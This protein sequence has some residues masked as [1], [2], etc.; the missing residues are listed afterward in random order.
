M[1][2][3]EPRP[4]PPPDPLVP[5][6]RTPRGMVV[7]ATA[8]LSGFVLFSAPTLWKEYQGLRGD[9]AIT[10]AAAPLGFVDIAPNPSFAEP[11]PD[12]VHAEGGDL[13][14]W[15]GWFGPDGHGWFRVGAGDLDVAKLHKP[16]GRDVIRAI[17]RPVVEV[18]RGE[19]WGRM[20]PET[21]V[22][23]LTFDGVETAYPQL[24]LQKVEVVND[25]INGRKV[26]VVSTPFVPPDRAVSVFD[27]T[28]DGRI[29]TFG[30]SGLFV[31]LERR[32]L[33]YD[34]ETE[35]LWM[36]HDGVLACIGGSCKGARLPSLA[37]L[38]PSRWREWSP[39][40]GRGRLVVGAERNRAKPSR[41]P[42]I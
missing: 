34:R 32:P 23:P 33:L 12:W 16:M 40:R 1:D 8:L 3:A 37:R 14:L 15:S 19:L 21:P 29:L 30:H 28:H 6:G 36:V 39:P 20:Q 4:S 41:S 7:G 11:P 26:T 17:D 25:T 2:H 38:T 22:L 18:G 35:S 31:G 27:P 13:L 10:R 9:W 24:L 5:P 42:A